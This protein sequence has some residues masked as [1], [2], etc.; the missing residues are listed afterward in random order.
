MLL[1]TWWKSGVTTFSLTARSVT[2]LTLFV[3]FIKGVVLEFS[4]EKREVSRGF[5]KLAFVE[6]HPYGLGPVGA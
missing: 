2:P 1:I 3:F 4:K 6:P 5:S